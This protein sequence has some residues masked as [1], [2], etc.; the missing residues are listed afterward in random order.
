[1][2]SLCIEPWYSS[3]FSVIWLV[4]CSIS[5]AGLIG[6]GVLV[7]KEG[8]NASLKR[9]DLLLLVGSN[10]EVTFFELVWFF[11]PHYCLQFIKL[12]VLNLLL[13]FDPLLLKR[14]LMIFWVL[15]F[16]VWLSWGFA[17]G[18]MSNRCEFFMGW[19]SVCVGVTR[20]SKLLSSW[21]HIQ[22]RTLLV[23]LIDS[24]FHGLGGIACETVVQNVA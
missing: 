10:L 17:L 24:C 4:L 7:G 6:E 16:D 2:I 11:S 14:V 5:D 19:S 15:L 23:S 22:W 13:A 1:M 8:L 3:A 9:K 12:L 20:L 18:L 21:S